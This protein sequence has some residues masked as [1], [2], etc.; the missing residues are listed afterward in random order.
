MSTTLCHCLVFTSCIVVKHTGG[1][2]A[3]E[4]VLKSWF[5]DKTIGTVHVDT[6]N[7]L[8]LLLSLG[9]CITGYQA[10]KRHH[11]GAKRQPQAS[12]SSMLQGLRDIRLS[13]RRFCTL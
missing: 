11:G 10:E 12:S 6:L 7:E 9:S 2:V 5:R 4:S 1:K 3:L 13:F 8:V